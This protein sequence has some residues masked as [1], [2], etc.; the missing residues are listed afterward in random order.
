VKTK[1]WGPRILT[2]KLSVVGAKGITKGRLVQRGF[3]SPN[4]REQD[5]G[6]SREQEGRGWRT[7]SRGRALLSKRTGSTQKNAGG[8]S[9]RG[10]APKTNGSR[11]ALLAGRRGCCCCGCGFALFCAELSVCTRSWLASL[12][13]STGRYPGWS[14]RANCWKD[15]IDLFFLDGGRTEVSWSPRKKQCATVKLCSAFHDSCNARGGRQTKPLFGFSVQICE[16]MPRAVFSRETAVMART[17]VSRQEQQRRTADRQCG[18]S[19]ADW[20]DCEG[21]LVDWCWQ[22]S[23]QGGQFIADTDSSCGSGDVFADDRSI[24]RTC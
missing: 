7:S 19:T 1:A 9:P 6:V 21:E 4:S 2:G 5:E 10:T 24:A 11:T 14:S 16:Y 3:C 20:W 18:I 15:V 22:S 12:S 17:A 13:M 23:Q 8:R